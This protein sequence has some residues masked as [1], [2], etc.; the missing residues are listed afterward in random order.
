MGEMVPGTIMIVT[1]FLGFM[2]AYRDPGV[3]PPL[4]AGTLGGLLA[5]WVTFV[6]CF[7]F[8]L[9]VAFYRGISAQQLW[10]LRCRA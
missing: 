10:T 9:V 6:P 7:L 8:I 4:L 2:A 5:V 1:Q 3:L